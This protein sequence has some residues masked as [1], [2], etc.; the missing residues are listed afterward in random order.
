MNG[1]ELVAK[2]Q[3]PAPIPVDRE[4]LVNLLETAEVL[5]QDN[6]CVAGWIRILSVDGAIL[7]QEETPDGNALARRMASI[8]DANS[9][10][11]NRLGT[12][13]RM[14]DGCGCKIN[15]FE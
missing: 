13:E 15:Y 5:R 7:V 9:F 4:N 8:E 3:S 10:V 12:Y 14:W 6:T 11:D 2:L 1:H